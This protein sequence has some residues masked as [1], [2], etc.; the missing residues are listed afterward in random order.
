MKLLGKLIAILSIFFLFFNVVNA[1]IKGASIERYFTEFEIVK[2]DPNVLYRQAKTNQ[3]DFFKYDLTFNENLNWSIDLH[4]REI[5]SENFIRNI[6]STD[7]F[8]RKY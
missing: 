8:E 2:F 6:G 5:F 7:S 4:V 1:Q 3:N